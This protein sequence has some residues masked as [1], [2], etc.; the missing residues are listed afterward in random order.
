MKN[1]KRLLIMLAFLLIPVQAVFADDT[2]DLF[3]D[4]E[5]QRLFTSGD[6]LLSTSSTAITQTAEGY[7][8]IGGYGGLVRY[9]GD[10]LVP[11]AADLLS[12]ITDLVGTDDGSLWIATADRGLIRFLNDEYLFVTED[13][14]I[15]REVE[16]LEFS[17]DGD[18][19]F[20]TESGVGCVSPEGK[21]A[22]LDIQELENRFIISMETMPDGRLLCV[23]R[24]GELY[25]YDGENCSAADLGKESRNIRS[26]FF[27]PDTETVYIGTLNDTILFCS[28]DLQVVKQIKTE[29]LNCINDLKTGDDGILWICSDSGIGAWTEE[30]LRIQKLQMEN[31]VDRVM[32]DRERNYWFV[33]SRQ[34]VLEVSHSR[35]GDIGQRAGLRDLVVNAVQKI[36]DRLYIG[37]DDGL[38][39][40]DMDSYEPIQDPDFD[41]LK[42][43]R[44]RSLY[45]DENGNIWFATKGKGLL[46]YQKDHTW[47]VFSSEDYPEIR[48]D[49]FRCIYPDGEDILAGTDQGAYR[50]RGDEA[51]NIL[52]N[53]SEYSRRVLCITMMGDSIFL[54]TDG[55]GL[56]E[57]KQGSIVRHLTK[58]KELT[59]NVIMKLTHGVENEGIWM[60]TGNSIGW[61]SIDGSCRI[62]DHFPSKNNLDLLIMESGEVWIPAGAGIFLTTED[63]L[64]YDEPVQTRLFRSADGVPH[65]A[66]ANSN[67]FLDEDV[68]YMCCAGG[69]TSLQIEDDGEEET[70]QLVIDTVSCDGERIFVQNMD[71]LQVRPAVKRIDIRADVLTYKTNDPE[72]Y[73]YLEGFDSDRT[74]CRLSEM[75]AISYTN[76]D[77]G[78]YVF[79]FGVL[80]PLTGEPQNN[81]VQLAIVKEN[82]WYEKT[83]VH[84]LG[85]VSSL[86]LAIVATGFIAMLRGRREKWLLK[87]EY[88]RQEK[89]HLEKIAYQDYLTGLFNR[90]YL[91]VWNEKILPAASYPVT[92]IL[93]DCNNLKKI[94]DRYGHKQGDAL[95]RGM[96][97][98]LKKEFADEDSTVFRAGGDEFLIVCCGTDRDQA[99]ERMEHMRSAAEGFRIEDIPLTFSY[100]TC[101]LDEDNFD[102]E[103]GLRRSDL[104]MLIEKDRFHGRR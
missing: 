49:N 62:I 57:V 65:E 97:G 47:K 103:E 89:Q 87:E 19:Y 41:I 67:Q 6:G 44:I 84:V 98:F 35:F 69:I 90:N 56:F 81:E 74:V 21:A 4:D 38:V 68:L 61:L 34:G 7:I 42:N 40:M 33:S 11:F 53:P 59:S 79:H 95:L 25:A 80:N 66:T 99:V 27:D 86:I 48:S 24:D 102:F 20:G 2:K 5:V 96:A 45:G 83:W 22:M 43:V 29:G 16:C 31:S 30:E 50:I 94:N 64:L 77:G 32:L 93:T 51:S 13:A 15:G 100:G 70:Y 1:V 73:Y 71:T 46:R 18:L 104:E 17:A 54:G 10:T 58:D 72:V 52:S 101:T 76:L 63:S 39:I 92:F 60:V 12:N 78:S 14:G 28:P 88:E 37:H 8:W 36:G 9:D 85:L 55:Y 3:I 75:S 26:V 23:T 82:R 91:E